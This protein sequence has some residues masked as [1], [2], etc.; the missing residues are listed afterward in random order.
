MAHGFDT[1]KSIDLIGVRQ[2]S[3]HTLGFYSI[4]G[5]K[6][7]AQREVILNIARIQLEVVQSTYKKQANKYRQNVQYKREEKV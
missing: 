2:S 4:E 5:A 6:W 3:N 7:I 1:F